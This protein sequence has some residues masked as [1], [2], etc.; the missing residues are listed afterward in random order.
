KR[1][2]CEVD[3]E[4]KPSCA[5]NILQGLK[6]LGLGQDVVIYAKELPVSY[7]AIQQIIADIW[8]TMKPKMAVHMGI[9]P[10]SKA[11]TLEQCGKNQG[12]KQ[13]DVCGACPPGHCCVE[14]GPDTLFSIIDMKPLVKR[15]KSMGLDIIYSRD[16]GRY[17]CEFAYYYSLYISKGKA[18]FLHLPTCGVLAD[19]G[20]LVPVLQAIIQAVLCQLEGPHAVPQHHGQAAH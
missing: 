19:M 4:L 2:H 13:R 20:R 7:T 10:G 3:R 6:R 15:F 12:Y 11:V 8:D 14:E 18:V 9:A 5:L 1:T 17:L 16:A